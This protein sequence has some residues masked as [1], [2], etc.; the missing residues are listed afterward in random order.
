MNPSCHASKAGLILLSAVS[1]LL[2]VIKLRE[3]QFN[4]EGHKIT[5]VSVL[6]LE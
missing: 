2:K 3:F 5:R 1:C 4:G 6:N